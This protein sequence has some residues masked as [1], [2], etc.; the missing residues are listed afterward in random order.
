MPAKCGGK[1]F[2]YEEPP[3]RRPHQRHL[4]IYAGRVNHKGTLYPGEHDAIVESDHV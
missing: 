2:T 3:L 1:L 4:P